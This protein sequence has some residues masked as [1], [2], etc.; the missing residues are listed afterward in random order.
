M[1]DRGSKMSVS[2]DE[3]TAPADRGPQHDAP[4]TAAGNLLPSFDEATTLGLQDYWH[5]YEKHYDEIRVIL[6]AE[7]ADDPEVGE[8][9]RRTPREALDEQGKVSRNVTRRAIVDGQWDSYRE[10]LRSQGL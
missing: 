7:L 5:L 2:S 9:I 3:R 10:H 4:S 8:L 1:A 6:L